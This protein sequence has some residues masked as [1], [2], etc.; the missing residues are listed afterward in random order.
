MLVLLLEEEYSGTVIVVLEEGYRTRFQKVKT[1]FQSPK[2]ESGDGG[3]TIPGG[4]PLSERW[5][6]IFF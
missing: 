3:R 5:S 2:S 4:G 6:Y 1:R